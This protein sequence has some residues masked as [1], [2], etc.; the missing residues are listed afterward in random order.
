[1]DTCGHSRPRGDAYMRRVTLKSKYLA[2]VRVHVSDAPQQGLQCNLQP[3]RF[4][5][6]AFRSEHTETSFLVLSGFTHT[7]ILKFNE[8]K[9]PHTAYY[10]AAWRLTIMEEGCAHA[11]L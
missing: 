5:I 1:M 2:N 9:V 6:Y 11:Q 8:T 7:Y 10:H 4:G 3:Y